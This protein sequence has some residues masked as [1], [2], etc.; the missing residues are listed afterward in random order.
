LSPS[1]VYFGATRHE[2]IEH[3]QR[4][5]CTHFIDDLEEVFLEEDFPGGV[6]KI[7]YAPHPDRSINLSS[8]TV[9]ST[10]TYI[11]DHLFGT[12]QHANDLH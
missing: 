5:G 3:I 10:W 9:F 11:S 1:C 6:E 12:N 7:L 4:L 8:I 2:K